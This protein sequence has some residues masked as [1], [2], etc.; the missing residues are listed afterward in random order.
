M[1]VARFSDINSQALI[2][3]GPD[4]VYDSLA[5]KNDI[6]NLLNCPVGSR[7]YEPE[8]GC[9]LWS[10]LWEPCDMETAA[11]LEVS[12]LQ[13]F[14]RWCE[15]ISIDRSKFWVRP[16]DTE[17]GY[18]INVAGIDIDTGTSFLYQVR[19]TRPNTSLN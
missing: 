13:S 8:Y 12:L 10:F 11:Q 19:T 2:N 14:Q 17:D 18:L 5:I 16:T 15:R 6:Y 7:L 9:A 4:V 1:A 3:G